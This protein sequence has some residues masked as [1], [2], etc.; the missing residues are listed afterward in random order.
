MTLLE[1]KHMLNILMEYEN[2]DITHTIPGLLN[3][4]YSKNSQTFEII[5]FSTGEVVDCCNWDE[6]CEILHKIINLSQNKV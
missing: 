4:F 6:A 3:L 2:C 1:V 5:I